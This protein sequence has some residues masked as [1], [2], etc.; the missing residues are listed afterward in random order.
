MIHRLTILEIIKDAFDWIL[1]WLGFKKDPA[2]DLVVGC[3]LHLGADVEC[4]NMWIKKGGKIFTQGHRI[5][6]S[7]T[8][9]IDHESAV[10]NKTEDQELLDELDTVIHNLGGRRLRDDEHFTDPKFTPTSTPKIGDSVFITDAL[11]CD[12]SGPTNVPEQM[13]KHIIDPK[14]RVSGSEEK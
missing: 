3:D 2:W 7:G 10:L 14:F 9:Q 11:V 8:I 4:T 6:C 1:A 12:K 13:K 5:N